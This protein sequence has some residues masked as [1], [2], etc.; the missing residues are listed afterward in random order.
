M[1]WC[2][3]PPP[4]YVDHLRKLPWFDAVM[5]GK[6]PSLDMTPGAMEAIQGL[7][8]APNKGGVPQQTLG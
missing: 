7:Y 1:T 3:G 2:T 5:D 4:A 6:K 8:K